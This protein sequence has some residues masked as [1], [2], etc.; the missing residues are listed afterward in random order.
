MSEDISGGVDY[1]KLLTTFLCSDA[2]TL[3]A[4]GLTYLNG[5]PFTATQ[6]YYISG[7]MAYLNNADVVDVTRG[8]ATFTHGQPSVPAWLSPFLTT[9]GV[10]WPKVVPAFEAKDTLFYSD[11]D[12]WVSFNS[13]D[14]VPHWIP[15]NTYKRFKQ[16]YII[17]FI[18]RDSANGTLV[19]DIEG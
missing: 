5:V 1:S 17:M 3:R 11:Q 19:I 7:L 4:S 12:C 14:E 9:L 15:K 6:T 13:P 18:V 10:S 2:C 16:R 8:W